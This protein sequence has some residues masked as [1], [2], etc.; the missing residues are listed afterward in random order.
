MRSSAV[1]SGVSGSL[2]PKQVE[3]VTIVTLQCGENTL[4]SVAPRQTDRQLRCTEARTPPSSLYPPPLCLP[5]NKPRCD[6]SPTSSL[7][8]AAYRAGRGA[9]GVVHSGR[10]PWDNSCT[11]GRKSLQSEQEKL[12]QGQARWGLILQTDRVDAR[13]LLITRRV[14]CAAVTRS[15]AAAR[16]ASEQLGRSWNWA[17]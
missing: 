10:Q 11:G 8:V 17:S 2:W 7:I 16:F 15:L 5:L 12:S 13:P 3:T 1:A 9:A 6:W 14:R 4:D